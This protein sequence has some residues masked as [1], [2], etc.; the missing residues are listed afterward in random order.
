MIQCVDGGIRE[1]LLI[2]KIKRD[3]DASLNPNGELAVVVVRCIN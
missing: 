2:K 1:A 3:I